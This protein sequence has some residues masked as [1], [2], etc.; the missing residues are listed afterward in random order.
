M[1]STLDPVTR[2][3]ALPAGR[4]VLLTD[5]VGFIQKLPTTLVT[6]FRATL[7]EVEESS[8]IV[9]VVDITHPNAA[10]QTHVVEEILAEMGLTD[11]PRVLV[12]NKIDLLEL[13]DPTSRED[14][15]ADRDPVS[16]IQAVVGEGSRTVC[17]SAI[18]GRG[19]PKLREELGRTL[20]DVSADAL[21]TSA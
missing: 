13:D 11:R 6:S 9:H 19:L 14:G 3:I 1:F 12:L 18:D 8:V 17:T 16:A 15:T 10:Q 7:E 2:K 21:P 4:E 5:T 20:A